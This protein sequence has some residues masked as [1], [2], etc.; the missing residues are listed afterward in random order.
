MWYNILFYPFYSLFGYVFLLFK[1]TNDEKRKQILLKE[2]ENSYA[3]AGRI[4]ASQ[5]F[6]VI[7]IF[8]IGGALTAFIFRMV[9]DYLM[10]K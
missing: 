9:Y 6:I 3:L 1:F 4:I 10:K 7:L 5:F 8:L 2:Y